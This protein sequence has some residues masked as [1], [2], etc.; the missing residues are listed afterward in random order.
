M[1][2]SDLQWTLAAG[3]MYK[4]DG[5]KFALID[6]TVGQQFS[7]NTETQSYKL[8]AYSL[9]NLSAGY[10]FGMAEVDLSVDNLL[11]NRSVVALSINDKAYQTNQLLSTNS[12]SFQAPRSVMGT[13]KIHY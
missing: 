2:S 10:S 3:V 12:Y 11:N 13:I 1:C 5:W 4:M 6:K 9:V 7:D 8:P